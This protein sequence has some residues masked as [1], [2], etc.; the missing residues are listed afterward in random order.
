MKISHL[1]DLC[2]HHCKNEIYIKLDRFSKANENLDRLVPLVKGEQEAE[3]V[4]LSVYETYG[5]LCVK[6]LE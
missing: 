5:D 6:R 4:I 3:L 2:A 1:F